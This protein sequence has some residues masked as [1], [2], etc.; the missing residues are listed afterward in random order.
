VRDLPSGGRPVILVWVKRVWR[1]PQALC[2]KRTW[3]SDQSGDRAAGLVDRAGRVETCR[4]VGQDGAS[5]AAIA[6]EFGVEWR[7]AMGAVRERGTPL[8]E[9]P[10]RLAGVEALGVDETVFTAATACQATS[11]VTGIVD[12]T[13]GPGP[14]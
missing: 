6:R 12:L 3:I 11:F 2:S 8:I 1:C 10:Q 9:D 7:T 4:R 14:A 5:V 13:R